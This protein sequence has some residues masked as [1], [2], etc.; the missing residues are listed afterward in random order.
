M[1]ASFFIVGFSIASYLSIIWFMGAE[2]GSR[3]L[4]LLSTLLIGIGIQIMLFGLI[5]QLLIDSVKESS[6]LKESSIDNRKRFLLNN[7]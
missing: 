7:D 5:G 1:G 4:L 6:N 3:P 2:I